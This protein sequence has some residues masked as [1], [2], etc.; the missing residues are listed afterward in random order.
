MRNYTRSTAAAVVVTMLVCGCAAG[1]GSATKAGGSARP[2]TLH[3]GT[4]DA[5]GLPA[6]DV[7]EEFARQ[8]TAL[9]DGTVVIEPVWHAAGQPTPPSWDQVVARRVMSGDLEMGLVPTRAWDTEGVTSLR[10]L[11]APF[12][13]TAEPV[14]D[15]VLSGDLVPGLLGGLEDVGVTGL[16]LLPEGMR[17]VFGWGRALSSVDDFQGA[18]IRTPRSD[19]VSAVFAG[20]GAEAADVDGL[21]FADGIADGSIV[22]AETSFVLAGGL[23]GERP[24][25]AANVVLFPKVQAL[26]INSDALDALTEAQQEALR[27]AGKAALAWALSDSPSDAEAAADFCH[28]GGTVTLAAPE[29][30]QAL[31]DATRSVYE[32]IARDPVTRNL[33]DA[34]EQVREETPR[35]PAP[36]AC[37]AS[38]R[39]PESASTQS[40]DQGAFPD[41]VY[42]LEISVDELVAAGAEESWSGDV[43]GQWTM[44]FDDGVLTMSDVNSRS[45]LKTETTGAYCVD[46]DRVSI[47]LFGGETACGDGVYYDAGWD[48]SGDELSFVDV[49]PSPDEDPA[50]VTALFA[51]KPWRKIG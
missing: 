18:T 22:G 24:T 36:L 40:G 28:A 16:A 9:S 13:I 46:D 48:L 7:I 26:V 5:P 1:G 20:L 44:S 27:G 42:R 23:P 45:G 39:P 4:D 51:S 43:A 35:E 14:L 6:A 17:H 3:I 33:I 32:E 30:V 38:T 12:L 2:V 31:E 41:G 34:I 37:E 15:T 11:N 49:V 10:A 8:V 21:A 25:T 50:D 29:D 19:T 47:D